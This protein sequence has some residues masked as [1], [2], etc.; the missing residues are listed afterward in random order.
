MISYMAT[1]EERLVN[2]LPNTISCMT[3]FSISNVIPL[4]SSAR[5]M[6]F[7]LNDWQQYRV[8]SIYY[9]H[10]YSIYWKRDCVQIP[11]PSISLQDMN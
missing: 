7:L 2:N 10:I 1:H 3:Q 11:N 9:I 5:N 8:C 6:L 4:F